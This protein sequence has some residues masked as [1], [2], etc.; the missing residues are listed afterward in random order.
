MLSKSYDLQKWAVQLID[1]I[2]SKR[3]GRISIVYSPT[4]INKMSVLGK[5]YKF[6]VSLLN[7][8]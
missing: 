6:F 5:G 7:F 8:I 3:V 1:P 4:D 2:Q